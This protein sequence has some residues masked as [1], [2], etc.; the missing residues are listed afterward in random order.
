M[1]TAGIVYGVSRIGTT[2]NLASTAATGG[3]GPYTYQWHRSTVSGFTP[4]S[5]DALSGATS[6]TLADAGPLTPGTT[7]YYILV[8]TDTGTS[9]TINSA[10][11]N[12]VPVTNYRG[13]AGYG[14]SLNFTP[15][16]GA[17]T[18]IDAITEITP[19]PAS[20]S[21]LKA[22]IG[23]GA[24]AGVEIVAPGSKLASQIKGKARY[25]KADYLYLQ[26]QLGVAGTIVLTLAQDAAAAVGLFSGNGF[27]SNLT[28]QAIND[29]GIMEYEFTFSVDGDTAIS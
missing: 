17:S 7:Y 11:F 12:L 26:G 21:E 28:E 5:G 8:V 22:K 24:K 6:L 10:Q 15:I 1:L 25:L 14:Y 16:G 20:V 29:S 9:G 4:G 19:P 18:I 27:L 3:T 23:S 13:V 2:S